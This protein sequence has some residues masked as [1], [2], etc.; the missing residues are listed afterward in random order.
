MIGTPWQG[1]KNLGFGGDILNGGSDFWN[2]FKEYISEFTAGPPKWR[3]AVLNRDH[4]LCFEFVAHVRRR[5]GVNGRRDFCAV[6][7]FGCPKKKLD[8]FSWANN[9]IDIMPARVPSLVHSYVEQPVLIPVVEVSEQSEQRR[10]AFVRAIVRLHDLDFCPHA[11]AERPDRSFFPSEQ[12]RAVTDRKGEEFGLWGR[13][14]LGLEDGDGIKEMIQCT[15]QVV[16]D[17]TGDERPCDQIGRL[18][19]FDYVAV[20]GEIR[21]CLFN[22]S[23]RL[24]INPGADLTLEGIDMCVRAADF[25]PAAR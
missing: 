23:I 14:T 13:I 19:N 12:L 11:T 4:N 7:H 8:R 1:R 22:E 3:Q 10:K 18:E 21:A 9:V 20:P 16:D 24:T 17:I 6:F 25:C 15:P 5:T 2:Q